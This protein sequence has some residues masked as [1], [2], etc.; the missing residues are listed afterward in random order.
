MLS[1]HRAAGN[2]RKE[3]LSFNRKRPPAEPDSGR[4]A[5]CLDRLGHEKTGQSHKHALNTRPVVFVIQKRNA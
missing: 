5:I 3:K 2:S 1:I 4:A